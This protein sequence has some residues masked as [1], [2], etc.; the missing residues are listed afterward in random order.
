ML[1][2][3]TLTQAAR[4]RKEGPHFQK[5][6]ARG[7]GYVKGGGGGGRDESLTF[8]VENVPGT[9]PRRYAVQN[10]PLY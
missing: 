5:G 10:A 4:H 8:R 2:H 7:P 6:S 1:E 3:K 9:T